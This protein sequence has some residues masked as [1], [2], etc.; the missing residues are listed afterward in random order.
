MQAILT[1]RPI[2]FELDQATLRVQPTRKTDELARSPH[3]TMKNRNDPEWIPLEWI[4]PERSPEAHHC[5]S[6]RNTKK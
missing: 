1:D 2:F 6:V 4:P 5:G 3:L